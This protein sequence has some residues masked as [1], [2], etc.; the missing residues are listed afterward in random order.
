MSTLLLPAVAVL[1]LP[2]A[3]DGG[4][5]GGARDATSLALTAQTSLL[6]QAGRYRQL[7][8]AV[9][10]RQTELQQARDAEQAARAQAEAEQDL[11]GSTAADLYRAT[12]GERLPVLGLS[13]HDLGATSDVLYRQA[14]ADRA[15]R[16]VESL[17]VRAARTSTALT[18]A[19]TRVAAAEAAVAD[20]RDLAAGVLAK[21]RS[22]VGDLTPEVS[23]QLAAL[24][25]IPTAGAQQDRNAS[26]VARWQDYLGRL[27]AAGIVPPSAASIADAT[28]LPPGMSPA[29][30]GTAGRC[31]V[32]SGPSSA[33]AP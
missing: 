5:A 33:T 25:A 23:A 12:P 28:H 3:D 4:S 19:T 14:L 15:D 30:D 9:A 11:V 10:Q 31:P 13:V 17:V 27:A 16:A 18:A 20:A 29:L 22:K 6:E 8:Q 1:V 2:G 21:V 7:E 32:S 24:G 26:A